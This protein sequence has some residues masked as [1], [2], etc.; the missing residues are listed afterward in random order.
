MGLQ[1][2]IAKYKNP[3]ISWQIIE[4]LGRVVDSKSGGRLLESKEGG[5]RDN[6][7]TAGSSKRS[8]DGWVPMKEENKL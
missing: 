4:I 6:I 1:E 3:R 2:K 5:C 7:L 8:Q